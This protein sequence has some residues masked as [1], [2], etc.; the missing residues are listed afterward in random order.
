MT[1]LC[2]VIIDML[3]DDCNL[4]KKTKFRWQLKNCHHNNSDNSYI[5]IDLV[6]HLDDYQETAIKSIIFD[7]I[8]VF[9]LKKFFDILNVI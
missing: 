1:W 9:W 7:V 6:E 5:L 4:G 8:Y 2:K 3:N